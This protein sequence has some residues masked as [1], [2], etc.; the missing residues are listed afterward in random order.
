MCLVEG[1]GELPKSMPVEVISRPTA[2]PEVA[3]RLC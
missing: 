3:N 2:F 1:S